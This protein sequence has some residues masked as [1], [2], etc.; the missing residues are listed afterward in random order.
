ME[1]TQEV[2]LIT[3]KD[4]RKGGRGQAPGRGFMRGGKM[5][6]R[7]FICGKEGHF[8]IVYQRRTS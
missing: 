4:P 6:G 2:R 8:V 1:V 7:G 3:D 5:A